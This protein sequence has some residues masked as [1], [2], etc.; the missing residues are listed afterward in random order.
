M[1]GWILLS[2]NKD[3]KTL[4]SSTSACEYQLEEPTSFQL[5]VGICLLVP[6]SW[7]ILPATY[8]VS[9]DLDLKIADGP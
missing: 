7:V 3:P 1:I 8:V 2:V 5:C 6:L 9:V 4:C